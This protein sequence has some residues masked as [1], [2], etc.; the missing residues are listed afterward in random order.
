MKAYFWIGKCNW[1][2]SLIRAFKKR[3][4]SH[5]MIVFGDGMAGTAS[6]TQGGIVYGRA[7]IRSE[8][9]LVIDVPGDEAPVRQFFAVDERGCGYDWWGIVFAQVLGWNMESPT[10]WFCSEACVSALQRIGY[11]RGKK[12]YMID[13]AGMLELLVAETR[14]AQF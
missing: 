6:V 13:P 12:A 10:K 9:W 5:V 2:G 4:V 11:F 8:D 7:E 3:G 1:W 14:V